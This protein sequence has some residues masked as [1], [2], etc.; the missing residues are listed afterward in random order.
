MHKSTF[1]EL[2]T[3]YRWNPIYGCPGRYVLAQGVVPTTPQQLIELDIEVF[4]EV[5]TQTADPVCYCFFE[6][7]GLISYR[8][9]NGYLHTLCDTDGMERKLG[10]LRASER[11]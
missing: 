3:R 5:F 10:M 11:P 8:K 2:R 4:E 6:G 7:G 1:D 9:K